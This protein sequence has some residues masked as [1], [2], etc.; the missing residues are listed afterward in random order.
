MSA[1]RCRAGPARRSPGT[2]AVAADRARPA[3][4]G[5][6]A[7]VLIGKYCDH[8]PL[9]RQAEI[10]AREGVALPRHAGRL[11]RQRRLH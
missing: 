7:H 2:D 10:Y 11:G 9:Y 8:L 4:S 1:R 5:L 3:G 6:L